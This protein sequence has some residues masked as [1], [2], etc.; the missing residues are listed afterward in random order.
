MFIKIG[1]VVLTKSTEAQHTIQGYMGGSIGIQGRVQSEEDV[2][3]TEKELYLLRE[4]QIQ[5]IEVL[6]DDG[7]SMTGSY[8]ANELNWKKEKKDTEIMNSCST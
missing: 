4:G 7:K 8:K 6:T 1:S 5:E 3:L 2:K